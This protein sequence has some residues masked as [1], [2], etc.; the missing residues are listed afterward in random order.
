MEANMPSC[1]A[2]SGSEVVP[3]IEAE[4][5]V[6][7]EPL[8]INRK[9]LHQMFV[10]GVAELELILRSILSES[11]LSELRQIAAAPEDDFRYS[12]DLWVRTVYEFAASYHKAVISRDHILQALAP[13]YR[14]KAY[15]F[16]VQNRD[17]SA[18]EVENNVEQLC[19]TFERYK[20]Y[21]LEV[22]NGRK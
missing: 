18:N 8:R 10:H 12:D 6:S 21:L 2:I 7:L 4:H 3:T 19:L 11:T 17:A 20:P 14:G 15:T 22:W 5:E 9:R 16:L 13:L 1:S